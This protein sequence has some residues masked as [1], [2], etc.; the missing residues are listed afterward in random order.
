[1]LTKG[2]K[3]LEKTDLPFGSLMSCWK[4]CQPYLHFNLH[5]SLYK[6]LYSYS[7]LKYLLDYNHNDLYMSSL[8]TLWAAVPA[9]WAI[10]GL[11][12]R[13]VRLSMTFY[14]NSWL[15]VR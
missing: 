8:I 3:G 1:M 14:P 4:A 15:L 11:A 12:A 2:R 6:V 9:H 7:A 5:A 10:Q 13:N